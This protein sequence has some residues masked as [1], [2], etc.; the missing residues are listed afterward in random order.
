[1]NNL[2]IN[3]DPAP[4]ELIGVSA[5]GPGILI[6]EHGGRHVPCKLDN[7]GLAASTMDE[8]IA[9]DIGAEATARLIANRLSV[10]LLIQR[11]SRLVIDCNRP[12]TA[13]DSMPALI[14]GT[15]VPGNRDLSDVD[16]QQRVDEIFTPYNNALTALIESIECRWAISI[17]SF[18]A[19]LNG[20][21]RPWEIGFLYRQ[22]NKTSTKL[23][24]Y[25]Q[26]H[27]SDLNIGLN[28]PYTIDDASDWFVPQH[29][30][31]LGIQHSLIEIRND[32]IQTHEG[33]L[34]WA[35]LIAEAIEQTMM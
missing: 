8:H 1:M 4:V 9:Y 34:H 26:S 7:L 14:H 6:C 10:P 15:T 2:L 24:S 16:K 19:K 22:D 20:K 23:A 29:G 32:Q 33:Q 25:L 17:H 35:G 31:R 18:T 13:V 27:Y 28:Q 11:Y 3:K 21:Q 12:P 30:E 5:P